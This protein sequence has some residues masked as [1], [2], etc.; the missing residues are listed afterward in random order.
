[1]S[2]TLLVK[3]A[4]TEASVSDKDIPTSACLRAAQSFAPSPHIPVIN[5]RCLSSL[6]KSAF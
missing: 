3:D 6:T 1:M 4:A 5:P 2:A